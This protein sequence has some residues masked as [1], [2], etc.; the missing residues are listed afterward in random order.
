[1]FPVFNTSTLSFSSLPFGTSSWGILGILDSRLSN[2]F[3]IFFCKSAN[4]S[5]SNVSSLDFLNKVS[6]FDFE[7]SFF[8]FSMASF[9]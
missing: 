7:I 1:M 9:Y 6:S 5:N 3:F 2:S 4:L 8:S